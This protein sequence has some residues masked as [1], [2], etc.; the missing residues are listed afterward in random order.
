MDTK[1]R[2]GDNPYRMCPK[3]GYTR[4]PNDP[5]PE[6]QCPQCQ[7]VYSKYAEKKPSPG[8]YVDTA[9]L[10]FPPEFAF[11]QDTAPRPSSNLASRL[12]YALITIIVVL[13]CAWYGMKLYLNVGASSDDII[14]F[15]KDDCLPCLDALKHLE[16]QDVEFIEY[17][18]GESGEGLV[19]YEKFGEPT[20]PFVI[21][22]KKRI[23]GYNPVLMDIAIN[24]IYEKMEEGGEESEEEI[25]E[26]SEE[27]V[28]TEDPHE[29][30]QAEAPDQ[31]KVFMYTSPGC[32]YC[33]DA[34]K[35]FKEHGIE[36]IEYD[37]TDPVNKKT[38]EEQGSPGTPLIFVGKNRIL[39]FN[40]EV[41]EMALREE[42]LL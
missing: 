8:N 39:G 18:V 23:E 21:I 4:T 28:E 22:G 6:G 34:R 32:A 42:D 26:E 24:A 11:V 13:A 10:K 1:E 14:V 7:I 40:K 15:T 12:I 33:V 41:V 19:K 5:G 36:Y 2:W 16:D 27:D 30:E 38:Y 9:E 31:A 25:V 37:I 20:L 29:Q 3:C 17:N 35:L